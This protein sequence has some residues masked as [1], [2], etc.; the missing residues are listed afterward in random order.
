MCVCVLVEQTS[1]MFCLANKAV[2]YSLWSRLIP[3]DDH[4]ICFEFCF[5]LLGLGDGRPMKS[6]MNWCNELVVTN[7]DLNKMEC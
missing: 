3:R 1:Y 2:S 7:V 5:E 6:E 4:E